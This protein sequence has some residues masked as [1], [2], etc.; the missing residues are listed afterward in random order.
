[1]LDSFPV[2]KAGH[3]ALDSIDTSSIQPIR[4]Q[5]DLLQTPG[6]HGSNGQKPGAQIEMLESNILP[7]QTPISG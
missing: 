7:A 1:M 6:F 5:L 2:G 4:I 3:A